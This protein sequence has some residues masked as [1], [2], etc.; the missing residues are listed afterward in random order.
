MWEEGTWLPSARLLCSMQSRIRHRSGWPAASL[1]ADVLTPGA[2]ITYD[3]D[4]ADGQASWAKTPSVQR[5]CSDDTRPQD[6]DGSRTGPRQPPTRSRNSNTYAPG[7]SDHP[8]GAGPGTCPSRTCAPRRTTRPCLAI[9]CSRPGH[10]RGSRSTARRCASHSRSRGSGSSAR[11][12]AAPPGRPPRRRRRVR[13]GRR[14]TG[15]GGRRPAGRN[16]NHCR[17]GGPRCS[18]RQPRRCARRRRGRGPCAVCGSRRFRSGG[19]SSTRGLRRRR[20][21]SAGCCSLWPCKGLQHLSSVQR[22]STSMS[23]GERTECVT[24]AVSAGIAVLHIEKAPTAAH[25]HSN[26]SHV[27]PT[28]SIKPPPRHTN[29]TRQRTLVAVGLAARHLG[30]A[31]QLSPLDPPARVERAVHRH[32]VD[33]AVGYDDARVVATRAARLASHV[34]LGERGVGWW[35]DAEAARR[36][37]TRCCLGEDGIEVHRDVISSDHLAKPCLKKA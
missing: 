22:V 5:R 31:A 37:V 3:K 15:G 8:H 29:K 27:Y 18:S 17:C 28:V 24:V 35:S 36:T 33:A 25:V 16:L 10:T 21:C 26:T 9:G 11:R 4:R 32:P 7:R 30:H 19:R 20:I 23:L 2:Y 6:R 34:G 14:G 13:S 1:E 12:S